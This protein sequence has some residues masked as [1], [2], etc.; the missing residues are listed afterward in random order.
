MN[1]KKIHARS[2][3]NAAQPELAKVPVLVDEGW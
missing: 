3:Q 2:A 1:T